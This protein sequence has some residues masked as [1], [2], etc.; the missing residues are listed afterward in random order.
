MSLIGLGLLK[1]DVSPMQVVQHSQYPI[2]LVEPAGEK[3]IFHLKL[4][5][6]CASLSPPFPYLASP[7]CPAVTVE[8]GAFE[9]CWKVV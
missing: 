8:P 3:R 1:D 2:A 9:V 7:C 5:G 6:S 4:L